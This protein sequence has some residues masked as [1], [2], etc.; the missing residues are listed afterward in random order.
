MRSFEALTIFTG[1][2]E[3]LLRSKE[4]FVLPI[5][6]I[7]ASLATLPNVRPLA[8]MIFILLV[9]F[10]FF[11]FLYKL[12]HRHFRAIRFSSA[13]F[14]NSRIPSFPVSI[15][16]GNNF[17]KFFD[18]GTPVHKFA[19]YISAGSRTAFF[20]TGYKLFNKRTQLFSFWFCSPD[21]SAYD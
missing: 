2:P 5:K 20:G 14:Q 18:F 17:K 11:I 4:T 1:I 21:F 16:W 8:S 19:D 7:A 9:S 3:Y 13:Q 10:A 6:D 12:Y 15:L